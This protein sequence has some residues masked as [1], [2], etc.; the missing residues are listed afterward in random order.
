MTQGMAKAYQLAVEIIKASLSGEEKDAKAAISKS[1]ILVVSGGY[2]QAEDVLDLLEIP[3]KL[4]QPH[5]LKDLQ[6][7]PSQTLIVNCPGSVN[8]KAVSKIASFVKDGG[9][10]LTSDWAIK[11]VVERA[12]PGIVRCNNCATADEVVRI[13]CKNPDHPILAG[14]LH[15]GSELFWW[16]EGSSYPITV[17]DD[18]RVEVLLTSR[19]LEH[20]YGEAPV[21]VKFTFGKGRVFHS[22]A[23]YYMKCTQDKTSRHKSSWKNYVNEIGA[24]SLLPKDTSN[25]DDLTTGHLEAAYTSAR[26]LHNLIVGMR[27]M[28]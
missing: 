13:E 23:H 3:F 12:F 1:D 16:I 19:E 14:C 9:T 28:K 25:Y 27:A 6:L 21:A 11:N 7:T 26:I 24:K 20:K 18:D 4:I 8:I 2:D 17:I 5:E 10:L 15:S 22:I